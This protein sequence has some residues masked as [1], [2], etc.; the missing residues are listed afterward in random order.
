MVN[1]SVMAKK[2]MNVVAKKETKEKPGRVRPSEPQVVGRRLQPAT[3]LTP[4]SPLGN[5]ARQHLFHYS[6]KESPLAAGEM[7]LPNSVVQRQL[8]GAAATNPLS[9]TEAFAAVRWYAAQ[10]Y[11]PDLIGQIQAKAGATADK[12]VGP[13]TVQAVARWQRANNLSVDGMAGPATQAAMFGKSP[14]QPE[15]KKPEE[16]KTKEAEVVDPA[17]LAE[18]NANPAIW[19][20]F[21][22][23]VNEYAR[24]R[25]L[26]Q[27][28][29]VA[30]PAQYISDNIIQV[31]FFG[32]N[33]PAHKDMKDKLKAAETDLTNQKAF[34]ALQ[35][36]WSFNPR[37]MRGNPGKLSEHAL[38]RSFD[39]NVVENPMV[40]NRE[41][42]RVIREVTGVDLGQKQSAEAMREASRA[43]MEKFGQ[44]K[45]D[46]VRELAKLE[47][48]G[49]KGYPS[50]GLPATGSNELKELKRLIKILNEPSRKAR[51]DGYAARGFLNLDQSL[52]DALVKAGFN[53]GGDWTSKKDFMHF[54]L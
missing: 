45:L 21:G 47:S 54:E 27:A 32:R 53:W 23:S 3:G 17:A 1:S 34:P 9:V 20:H 35:N 31:S 39:V 43:F 15:E 14:A 46:K 49:Q 50:S 12:I 36:F 25:P 24:L 44:W 42:I 30:N 22:K 41:D 28:E 4:V 51:L 13:Q 48:E 52:I 29:G 26:Y 8:E 33:T 16:G 5:S 10:R 38:G 37:T 6:L 19:R 7:P 2:A 40:S 11:A 18:W